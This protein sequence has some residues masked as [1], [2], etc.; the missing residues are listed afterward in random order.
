MA[1][2][3][4]NLHD[5][6]PRHTKHEPQT[7]RRRLKSSIFVVVVVAVHTYMYI[8]SS[9]SCGSSC[10]SSCG[11][12]VMSQ[13]EYHSSLHLATGCMY[14]YLIYVCLHVGKFYVWMCARMT[15]AVMVTG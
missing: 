4:F 11:R 13:S 8:C 1:D 10:L 12:E 5:F 15:M 6:F 2:N 14:V 9:R 7:I 3:I